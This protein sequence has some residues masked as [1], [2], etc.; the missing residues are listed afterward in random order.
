MQVVRSLKKQGYF[1]VMT[2]VWPANQG[3]II[4]ARSVKSIALPAPIVRE[5][6]STVIQCLQ[7]Y[8]SEVY[9]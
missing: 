2:L 8:F 9:K 6:L 3:T 1:D 5:I 7:R 4:Y